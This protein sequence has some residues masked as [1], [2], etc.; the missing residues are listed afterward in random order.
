[1]TQPNQH[2]IHG[3][4]LRSIKINSFTVLELNGP[5][6][7]FFICSC[8]EEACKHLK[9]AKSFHHQLRQRLAVAASFIFS[10]IKPTTTKEE[11]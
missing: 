7:S 3:Y 8:G 4:T 5:R 1:M 6:G 11:N 10:F 9:Q 2:T